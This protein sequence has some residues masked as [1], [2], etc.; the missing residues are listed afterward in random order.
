MLLNTIKFV[1]KDLRLAECVVLMCLFV[2]IDGLGEL[3]EFKETQF[4]H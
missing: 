1:L 3:P 2:T 4:G